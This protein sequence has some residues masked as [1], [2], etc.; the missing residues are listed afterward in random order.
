MRLRVDHGD[1]DRWVIKLDEAVS[2]CPDEAAKVV[3]RG[4]LQVKKGSQR[5]VRRMRHAPAYPRSI[6]Y[7]SF[8]GLRGPVAE[9][10]PDK[11]RRQ[12][13]LGNL[14]EFG[15]VNNPPRPHI[16]P[17]TEDELPRF[18]RAMEALAAKLL[19]GR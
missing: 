15:S 6:G 3:N 10:G 17:A 5:R 9:I 13:A 1:I 11:N 19:E 12:G 16:R 2:R 7:D 18:E 14:I 4:A 8:K